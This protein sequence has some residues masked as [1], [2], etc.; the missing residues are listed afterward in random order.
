MT[1]NWRKGPAMGGTERPDDHADEILIVAD[2]GRME[3][4]H[5]G[6]LSSDGD[7]V[8]ICEATIPWRRVAWWVPTDEIKPPEIP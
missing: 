6:Y 1:I 4:I 5:V 8:W 2:S 3:S 7:E